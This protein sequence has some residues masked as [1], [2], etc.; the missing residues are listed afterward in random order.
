M[1]LIDSLVFLVTKAVGTVFDIK[2]IDGYQIELG[3][4]YIITKELFTLSGNLGL[5]CGQLLA[6]AIGRKHIRL[7]KATADAAAIIA[8]T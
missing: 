5:K 1:G 7:K 4:D 3:N 2:D 6:L 8:V